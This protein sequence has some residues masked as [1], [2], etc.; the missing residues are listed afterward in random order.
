MQ[1]LGCRTNSLCALSGRQTY[2]VKDWS[3]NEPTSAMKFG[4]C[5]DSSKA[6]EVDSILRSYRYP[7]DNSITVAGLS[8]DGV[9]LAVGD[10]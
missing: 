5:L 4:G 6:R 1:F 9:L 10:R 3:L 7:Q 2:L 8:E